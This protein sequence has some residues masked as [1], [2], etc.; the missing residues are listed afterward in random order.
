M[1]GLAEDWKDLTNL[2]E[3]VRNIS[4]QSAGHPIGWLMVSTVTAAGGANDP[5]RAG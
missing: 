4:V 3:S 1:V 5:P 2:K